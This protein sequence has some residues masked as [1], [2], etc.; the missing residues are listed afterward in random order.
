V[1]KRWKGKKKGGAKVG[2]DC[3]YSGGHAQHCPTSLHCLF[4]T[5]SSNLFS[6]SLSFSQPIP[7]TVSLS[8]S[9]YPFPRFS[10]FL[11]FC[12]W[13]TQNHAKGEAFNSNGTTISVMELG[14]EILCFFVFKLGSFCG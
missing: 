5:F 11:I 1:E 6:L 7:P 10:F 14:C 4:P 13:V 12:Y 8:K 2:F 9:H 3:V